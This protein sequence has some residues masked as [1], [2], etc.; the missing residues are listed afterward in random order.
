MMKMRAPMPAKPNYSRIEVMDFG[1]I[2]QMVMK[3]LLRRVVNTGVNKGINY[4][5][6]FG[7]AAPRAA[8]D[9]NSEQAPLDEAAAKRARQAASRARRLRR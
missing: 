3:M 7:K 6:R 4:A 1:R 8:I 9:K 2:V 5:S